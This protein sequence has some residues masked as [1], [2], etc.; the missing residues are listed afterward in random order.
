MSEIL[1]AEELRIVREFNAMLESCARCNRRSDRALIRKAFKMAR[2]AHKGSVRMS[3]DPYILHP[4]AVARIV[5]EEMGLG[6]KAVVSALLHDVVEDTDFS[7]EDIENNFGSKIASIIDGL[8]K[9]SGVFDKNSSLQAENFRKMLLTLS[10]DVRVILIKLADRLHNMRTLDALPPHKQMKISAETLYLY[11]PLAHRMGFFSIKS[12]LEDLSLKY[13]NPKVFHDLSGKIKSREESH[14]KFLEEFSGPIKTQLDKNNIHYEI[15]GRY[16]SIFSVW[17]KMQSKNIPFEEVY[18]LMAVRIVFEPFSEIPEKTQC[19]NIYSMITDVYMPKPERIRDWVSTPKANG[20]EAL[21]ATVMGP[22]GNWVEVQI[23]STRMDE[24]AERG[25]AAH[26]KYKTDSSHESELDKWLKRIRELLSNPQTDALEFLD[27]FKLNLFAS[28]IFIFTP[29]GDIKTLPVNSTALDFAYEIH[30]EIGHKAIGAK[31]NHRLVPL[32]HILKSGDQVE[33]IT[34]DILR[35]RL[36]WLSTVVTVKAKTAIKDAL[37]AENKN[38]IEKGKK[39]LEEQ[40][41]ELKLRPNARII[42]KLMTEH[43]TTS[44][45]ELYSKIGTGIL[46]LD[47]LGEILKRNTKNKWVNYWKLQLGISSSRNKKPSASGTGA[48]KSEYNKPVLLKENISH[49]EADYI[50]AGCCNPIP[51][52]NVIAFRGFK[53][54]DKVVIHQAKCKN[55]VRLLSSRSE[56]VV[57]VK[58][59]THKLLSFLVKIAISGYDR[60]GIYNDITTV[61]SKELNVNIRSMNLSSHDGIWEG[62]M[63]LYVHDTKDLNNLL[64]SLSKLKGV[65]TVT[66]VEAES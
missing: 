50:I 41:L 39:L 62:T 2:E 32:N 19:W 3:G 52:D 27:D 34:S 54:S 8:T 66:R 17:H 53:D 29:K 58:W 22:K 55:A 56:M 16:K 65:D 1:T 38:R 59:T 31:V 26:W 61:I 5:G 36:E 23:R 11:A 35:P 20:Y 64:V 60:F 44:K 40:L 51:G 30:S 4:I 47:N 43:E 13:R 37:K 46:Q 12:E 7:L 21:H 18:D 24:I 9:I 63:D 45:D 28:E 25:F 42:Q 57:P 48:Q 33:I 14:K 49:A 10:D 15:S 6:V